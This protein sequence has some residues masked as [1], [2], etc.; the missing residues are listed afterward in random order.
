MA[1][2]FVRF[3]LAGAVPAEHAVLLVRG[4]ERPFALVGSW[5]SS[6]AVCGS[7]PRR[8]APPGAEAF[9]VIGLAGEGEGF[10]GAG[11]GWSTF[12]PLSE[13]NAAHP[14]HEAVGGGWFGVLG[15]QLGRHVERIGD[16][17]P[18]PVP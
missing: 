8:S 7:A 11:G 12:L 15:Y 10:G 6:A 9:D 1:P 13:T 3:P 16:P 17:P 4:D 14:P 18:R 2:R 5:A